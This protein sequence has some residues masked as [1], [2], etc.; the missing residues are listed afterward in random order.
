MTAVSSDPPHSPRLAF[1]GRRDAV[2]ALR[3]DGGIPKSTL[4]MRRSP[5]GN[6]RRRS[7]M[8]VEAGKIDCGLQRYDGGDR[9]AT[10]EYRNCAGD[11]APGYR[12]LGGR[13]RHA[14]GLVSW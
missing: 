13:R 2:A 1:R 3:L 5:R 10:C 6:H 9:N 12:H 14:G 7:S 11:E 8:I 4:A